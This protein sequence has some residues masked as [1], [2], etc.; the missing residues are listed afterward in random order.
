MRKGPKRVGDF[1]ERVQLRRSQLRLCDVLTI[2][3]LRTVFKSPTR[4]ADLRNCVAEEF[5]G[6]WASCNDEEMSILSACNTNYLLVFYGTKCS[7][8]R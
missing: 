6:G 4:T 5:K 3:G 7:L 1:G 8:R 2:E